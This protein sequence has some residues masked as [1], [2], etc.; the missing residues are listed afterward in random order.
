M[1]SAHKKSLLTAFIGVSVLAVFFIT[2]AFEYNRS[3][4]SDRRKTAD[5]LL[6]ARANIERTLTSRIIS[7]RGLIAY[8]QT[9][10]DFTQ[11]A[12]TNFAQGIFE[13]DDGLVRNMGV[14]KDTTITHVY[15]FKG[16]EAVIGKDLSAIPDQRD[17]VLAVK[18]SGTM[19]L[20]AP[21]KLIQGGTGIIVRLPISMR[22]SSTGAP[23]Y[24]GQMSLIFDY[25][26]MLAESGLIALGKS[27][28]VILYEQNPATGGKQIIWS[29]TAAFPAD[30]I[31]EIIR[32]YQVD[33]ELYAEPKSGWKAATSTTWLILI[34]GFFTAAGASTGIF[35]LL[36]ANDEL[37]SKVQERTDALAS[38]NADLVQNMAELEESQSELTA[39]NDQL[40]QSLENL[41]ETQTQLIISEKLA[42]LGELVAGVAHEINTPLGIGVTLSSYL[43]KLNSTLRG[44]FESNVLNRSEL[45]EY[46][47]GSEEALSL[48]N[49]NLERASSLVISFKQVAVDQASQERRRFKI[50]DTVLD[51]LKSLHPKLKNTPFTLD[52][53]CDE[54]LEV[55][56]Y[57]GALSQIIT[58]FVT[59]SLIHGFDDRSAGHMH[60]AFKR[61]GSSIV[62]LYDDNGSGIPEENLSKVFNPFFS[63]RKASGGTGL[64][65]HIVHNIVTQTL[66]GQISLT[67]TYQHGVHFKIVFE[68][69]NIPR[70]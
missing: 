3:L 17:A 66:G 46:L 69:Q 34:L 38:A 15:P 20:T 24:W 33:W 45:H 55:T 32:L 30:G 58:N 49:S 63:T 22:D 18:A 43:S 4:E 56:S 36:A 9:H 37:E 60:I 51:V 65:L 62:L 67:S 31:S 41:L 28:D 40:Q 57:P 11:E 26:K 70:L 61:T 50:R 44:Q 39:M 21:V 29:N 52:L 42:A 54:E 1:K 25:D 14:L 13:S 10:P 48:L 7:T 8:I 27:H 23:T 59:N 64:G 5:R 35:K 19:K 53:E 16:N 47:L 6:I 2:A 12:Y 68:D